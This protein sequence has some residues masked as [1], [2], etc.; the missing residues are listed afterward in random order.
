MEESDE[1]KEQKARQG[2]R[3]RRGMS[4]AVALAELRE[5][6]KLGKAALLRCRVRY[7]SDGL[8]LGSRGFVESA[9]SAKRS[10]FGPKRK[11]GARGLPVEDESLFSLRDLKVRALE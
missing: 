5:G 2:R 7:F 4:R 10:W 3:S 6:K 1:T 9:F 8:V 11:T